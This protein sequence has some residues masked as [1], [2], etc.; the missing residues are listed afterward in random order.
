MIQ[1]DEMLTCVQDM[2]RAFFLFRCTQFG[3]G[4]LLA[5]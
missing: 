3:L 2:H 4:D 1:N 5:P